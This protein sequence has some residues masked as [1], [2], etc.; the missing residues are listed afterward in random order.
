MTSTNLQDKRQAQYSISII[1][2]SGRL[3]STN[4]EDNRH[5]TKLLSLMNRI[6][7]EKLNSLFKVLMNHSIFDS[8]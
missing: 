7:V 1:L 2:I 6:N 5:P 3:T 8:K 4:N